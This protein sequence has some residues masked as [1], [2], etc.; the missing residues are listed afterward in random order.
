[1]MSKL[2]AAYLA[3]YMD[4][5]G[6]FSI[7]YKSNPKNVAGNSY[8]GRHG[9]VFEASIRVGSTDRETVQWLKDSYGGS[10]STM[11]VPGKGFHRKQA[12]QW[13]LSKKTVMDMFLKSIYPYLRFKK[14]HAEILREF[15]ITFGEES[16]ESSPRGGMRIKD[17][18]F[19]KRLH[20]W[21]EI[22]F[23][24]QRGVKT[25]V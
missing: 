16:Y 22:A 11:S 23:L 14:R 1:M 8:Y 17:E 21:K 24:N 6:R 2:T 12:Y 19:E 3:G 15:I 25:A 5:E 13:A 18:V 7:W 10:F 4:G 9:R 20:L